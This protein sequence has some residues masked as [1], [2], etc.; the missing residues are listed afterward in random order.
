VR[1]PEPLFPAR[2][3]TVGE[4]LAEVSE[5]LS[6]G[7]RHVSVVGQVCDL[8]RYPSGHVYFSLKDEG[9]KLS[10]VMW[11]SDAARLRFTLEEG[12]EAVARGTLGLYAARGQFQ[13]QVEGIEPVGIGALALAFEQLKRRLSAEGLFA[14]ARKRPLPQ[15]PKRIALVTSPS[16]AAVS[17]ILQVLSRRH[18]RIVVTI[19]P[20]RVQGPEAAGE[21]AEAVRRA[22]RVG[23]FDVLLLARGGGSAE[24]LAAF[25]DEGLA[26]AIAASAIPTISAVG[27]ETDWTIADYVADCRAATPSAA[28][29]LVVAAEEDLSRRLRVARRGLT[30]SL[31]RKV[32]EARRR[33]TESS[34]AESLHRF[35]YRLARDRGRLDDARERIASAVGRLPQLLGGRVGRATA[36]LSRARRVLAL[37]RR[38]GEAARAARS[39]SEAWRRR[40]A[41]SKG[42]L[43]GAAD[44]LSALDPLAVLARGYAVAFPAQGGR[45][46]TDAASVAVGDRLRI[47]L[48]RGAL[49]VAVTEKETT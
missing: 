16:G 7:W 40:V 12:L 25:N 13:I 1:A 20:V 42:L 37:A 15:L 32:A 46:V 29:E 28:A 19:F 11:R 36:S 48:H 22:N 17:D 2:V 38:R 3:Y 47:R 24:D 30:Q 26:R 34:S 35:R 44:R 31:R 21:I 39:L 5:A 14:A 4:I 18:P 10:A 49:G 43:A 23:I 9:G 6:T 8:K 27:H 41:A 45:P 33:A